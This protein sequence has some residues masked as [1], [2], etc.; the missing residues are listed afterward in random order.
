MMIRQRRDLAITPLGVCL[1]L[2]LIREKNDQSIN[3]TFDRSGRTERHNDTLRSVHE[4]AVLESNGWGS[5][6]EQTGRC[7]KRWDKLAPP[8]SF[9]C[10]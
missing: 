10:S 9:C 6:A 8:C 3:R 5:T 7:G 1:L 4:G 2:Y